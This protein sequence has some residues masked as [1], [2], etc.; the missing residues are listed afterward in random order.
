M[1]PRRAFLKYA[2]ATTVAFTGL[3]RWIENP[4][5]AEGGYGPLLP[6]EQ[7]VLQLPRGFSYQIISRTG[8]R[9]SDG[10][11]VPGA[12]DGMA[13]FG[14][15]SGKTILVRNHELSLGA[16]EVGPFG[17]KNVLL[18]KFR[19][20]DLYDAAPGLGGTT[21]LVYNTRTRRLEDHYLSLAGTIRNCAGGPTPWNS[22][23]S[24]EETTERN[25]GYNFEVPAGKGLA[26]PV[27]L[28]AMGRFNHEAIAVGPDGNVY[29]TEDRGDGLIYRFIPNRR[30]DLHAGG[31]LQALKIRDRKSVNT[32]N[33]SGFQIPLNVKLGVEWVDLED[34]ESP[35]DDLRKQGASLDAATFDRG[36][37]MW[38]GRDGIYFACTGGGRSSAG[39]IW[40]YVPGRD[41]GPATLELFIEPNDSRVLE[42]ADNLTVAPWGGLFICEDGP[43]ENR[44]LGVTP[45]GEIYEFAR[46]VMNNSELAGATFSPDATTLFVNIQNPGLTLAITGPWPG[47]N[48]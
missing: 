3:G 43:G 9:M 6:D 25:H 18:S 46:N 17:S 41:E 36:E 27:P 48:S 30:E 2:T 5:F 10:F 15:P 39:Q 7:K 16:S 23:I 26:R 45:Q 22:W 32:N 40:R 28:K 21:T 47:G 1:I 29:E 31:R 13:A 12:H 44:V 35:N 33:R 4:V 20:S 14:D 11:L 34:V 38:T 37:G 42:K 8:E 19:Q 24:C